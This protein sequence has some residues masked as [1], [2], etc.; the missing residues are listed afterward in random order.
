MTDTAIDERIE[1][2]R[3]ES[4]E[5]QGANIL[6]SQSGYESAWV[7]AQ[8]VNPDQGDYEI[9]LEGGMLPISGGRPSFGK[10]C[11]F[12]EDDGAAPAGFWVS[13]GWVYRF[14]HVSGVGATV[15]ISG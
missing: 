8:V 9:Y 12:D 6:T 13:K 14:R 5:I 10:F 1:S 3:P 7:T 11:I 4:N 15:R 2:A